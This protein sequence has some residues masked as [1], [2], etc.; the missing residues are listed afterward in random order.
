MSCAHSARREP[1]LSRLDSRPACAVAM[2]PPSSRVVWHAE[3]R[4]TQRPTMRFEARFSSARPRGGVIDTR[5]WTLCS[6]RWRSPGVAGTSAPCPT[7]R[8]FNFARHFVIRRARRSTTSVVLCRAAPPSTEH[9]RAGSG[10]VG[11]SISKPSLVVL[12]SLYGRD[13]GGCSCRGAVLHARAA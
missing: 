11:W 6:S 9:P 7:T 12:C 3:V 10:P 5:F 4:L 2:A 1:S 13:D 8:A